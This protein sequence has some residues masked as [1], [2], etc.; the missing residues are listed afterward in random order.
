[1]DPA[2]YFT[3]AAIVFVVAAVAVLVFAKTRMKDMHHSV[4]E[5]MG[6]TVS[7]L[8]LSLGWIITI[9]VSIVAFTIF[10]SSKGIS[11]WLNK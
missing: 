3:V 11:K 4:E 2:F 1:M 8:I 6:G 10:F 9:P 7:L 5:V